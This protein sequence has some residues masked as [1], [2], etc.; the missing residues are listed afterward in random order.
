MKS[1]W[2]SVN[3]KPYGLFGSYTVGGVAGSFIMKNEDG[4]PFH[5]SVSSTCS[6]S[7][8]FGSTFTITFPFLPFP[9]FFFFGTGSSLRSSRPPP[10][11]SWFNAN[12]PFG[13]NALT[14]LSNLNPPLVTVV[15]A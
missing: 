13:T 11:S 3:S 15:G 6:S 2:P 12:L 10:K 4:L 14:S 9:P 8:Y 1:H 7:S 5:A